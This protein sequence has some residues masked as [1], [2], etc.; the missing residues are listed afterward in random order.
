MLFFLL[1]FCVHL[2][3]CLERRFRCLVRKTNCS[4]SPSTP[5]E[6]TSW[7]RR[8]FRFIVFDV[9]GS[10]WFSLAFFGYHFSTF[11][12]A[13]PYGFWQ[14]ALAPVKTWFFFVA[15]ALTLRAKTASISSYRK[16]ALQYGLIDADWPNVPNGRDDQVS[17]AKASQWILPIW[18]Q[19]FRFR[20]CFKIS[21]VSWWT[22]M[23]W[24]PL[25]QR[26]Y[27]VLLVTNCYFGKGGLVL[28]WKK[29]L[30]FDTIVT[31]LMGCDPAFSASVPHHWVFDQKIK[32]D[33][34]YFTIYPVIA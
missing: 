12:R 6:S 14:V 7:W 5:L 4:C 10:H 11:F 18:W 9:L 31:I 16:E 15:V 20:V 25:P 23:R 26:S 33:Q 21:R 13:S 8:C 22:A 17:S 3:R 32:K 2:G 30:I 29:G 34:W 19:K 1:P 24:N 28:D 27:V